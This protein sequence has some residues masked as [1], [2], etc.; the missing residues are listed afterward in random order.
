MLAMPDTAIE[1]RLCEAGRRFIDA[2]KDTEA[3]IREAA[4]GG[5]TADAISHVSGLSGDT[6]SAFLRAAR[7]E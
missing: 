6:V 7:S 3:A 2:H 4:D 5:M 1:R